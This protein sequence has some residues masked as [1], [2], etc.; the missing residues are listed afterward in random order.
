M[1]PVT[2]SSPFMSTRIDL[3]GGVIPSDARHFASGPEAG[4]PH[5][6]PLRRLTATTTALGMAAAGLIIA[7]T[8]TA[9]ALRL[10]PVLPA[11][12][13]RILHTRLIQPRRHPVDHRQHHLRVRLDRH[14][15]APHL[16]HQP[17]Q[18]QGIID[19]GYTDTTMSDYEEDHLVPL[20][21]GGAP[22][23]TPAT[24]GPNRTTAPRPPPPRTA[25]RP[26]SRTPSATAPSHSPPPAPPSKTT[27]PPH[28]RSPESA[29][30]QRS[31][32][33][34]R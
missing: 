26:N 10:F 1:V 14:H 15:P 28:S 6:R 23:A 9:H 17:P 31:R 25:P 30:P 27:G 24:C 19:Y 2:G 34:D 13:R 5:M 18:G 12:A 11:T 3:G 32:R 22:R 8:G 16:L 4:N 20:E 33:P 21:L 29:D 7:A